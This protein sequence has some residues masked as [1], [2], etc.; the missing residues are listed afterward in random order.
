M[1]VCA[2]HQN[3][4]PESD[5]NFMKS[6]VENKWIIQCQ[7]FTTMCWLSMFRNVSF[8]IRLRWAYTSG[9]EQLSKEFQLLLDVLRTTKMHNLCNSIAQTCS[10]VKNY[11]NG[12]EI[13]AD[14]DDLKKGELKRLASWKIILKLSVEAKKRTTKKVSY[15]ARN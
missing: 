14:K 6:G 3:F 4:P 8:S 7:K 15:F 13:M 11:E 12:S 10:T 1:C 2:S 9:D 5:Q